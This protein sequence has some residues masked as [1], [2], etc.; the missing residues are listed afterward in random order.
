MIRTIVV[1]STGAGSKVVVEDPPTNNPTPQQKAQWINVMADEDNG[2]WIRHGDVSVAANIGQQI[3]P[4][5]GGG[6]PQYPPVSGLMS[7]GYVLS[8]LYIY[9]QNADDRAYITCLVR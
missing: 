2:G 6:A 9:F 4:G 1:V 8:E 5:G 3:T 7:Y